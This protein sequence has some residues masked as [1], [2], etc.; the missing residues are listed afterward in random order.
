MVSAQSRGK[1]SRDEGKYYLHLTPHVL[2]SA[3]LAG[4]QSQTMEL[5]TRHT[6]SVPIR[7]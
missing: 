2:H 6:L 5:A 7:R 3:A 4:L 1:C